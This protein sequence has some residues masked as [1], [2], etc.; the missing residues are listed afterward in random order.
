MNVYT[1]G[2]IHPKAIA[3]LLRRNKI[4]LSIYN[5][6]N[7]KLINPPTPLPTRD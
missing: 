1:G 6:L 7:L 3:F 5:Y 4:I 2:G